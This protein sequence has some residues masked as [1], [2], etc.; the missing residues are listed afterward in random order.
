MNPVAVC[1][2]C[3][4]AVRW[5]PKPTDR[6][7]RVLAPACYRPVENGMFVSTHHTSGD[8]RKAAAMVTELLL[9]DHPTPCARH[10]Q[11]HDCEL[12]VMA[13]KFGIMR[14]RLHGREKTLELDLSSD[15]I[16]VDHNACILCDRCIRGCDDIRDN[17]VLGRMNKGRDARIAFDLNNPMGKSTCVSC[18]ECMVSC[19]TGA[20]TNRKFVQP[21]LVR[22]GQPGGGEVVDPNSLFSHPLFEGVSV[23]FMG[24]NKGSV[25]RRRFKKG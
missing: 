23:Q 18:G 7:D 22:E 25:V 5:G 19:P 1:L 12:E 9:A 21:L 2:A 10:A 8:V 15:V 24:W 3:S 17:Q 4:V 20:L 11:H 13:E 6:R 16:A 14:S